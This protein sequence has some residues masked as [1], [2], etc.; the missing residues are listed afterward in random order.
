MSYQ[1][2][3]PHQLEHLTFL[4]PPDS[5]LPIIEGQSEQDERGLIAW[6]TR[7]QLR[8][9]VWAGLAIQSGQCEKRLEDG[10]VMVIEA[11]QRDDGA[12]A[13]R[14]EGHWVELLAWLTELLDA[15][16]G[17]GGVETVQEG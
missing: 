17:L 13:A 5:A 3:L 16:A 6:Y 2:T 8:E 10:E 7:D 11:R 9:A 14:L 12:E 4:I 15:Q 1:I